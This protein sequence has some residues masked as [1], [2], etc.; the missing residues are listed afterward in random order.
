[1]G[2]DDR[3]REPAWFPWGVPDFLHPLVIRQAARPHSPR[4]TGRRFS[5]NARMPSATSAV[6]SRIV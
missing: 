1:M 6:R 2:S 5:P 4:N 3:S